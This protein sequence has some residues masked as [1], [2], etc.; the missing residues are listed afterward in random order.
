MGKERGASKFFGV[1]VSDIITAGP[2]LL[3]FSL[4]PF[5]SHF[6]LRESCLFFSF[7]FSFSRQHELLFPSSYFV[8]R[9]CPF[10][11]PWD[12]GA[13]TAGYRI[14]FLSRGCRDFTLL[15]RRRWGGSRRSQKP[16]RLLCSALGGV[17][18]S[19]WCRDRNEGEIKPRRKLNEEPKD[20][21]R[22]AARMLTH[23]HPLL[24]A[25][26]RRARVLFHQSRPRKRPNTSFLLAFRLFFPSSRHRKRRDYSSSY[27]RAL[28]FLHLLHFP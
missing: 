16:P 25:T 8:S 4:V 26:P 2:S 13:N 20:L 1:V 15:E 24:P 7:V 3:V 21:E 22:I 10:Q 28:L 14:N 18:T 6:L 17:S 5:P 19:A 9:H 11:S 12:C 23:L 27:V